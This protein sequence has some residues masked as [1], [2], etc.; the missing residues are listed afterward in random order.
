LKE[1]KEEAKMTRFQKEI[2]GQLGEFWKKNAEKP[3]NA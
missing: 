2:S 1:F 3:M